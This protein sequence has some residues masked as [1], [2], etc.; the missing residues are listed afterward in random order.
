V[1]IS[2][3]IL[4]ASTLLLAVSCHNPDIFP[5]NKNK[6][7]E[8]IIKKGH[9]YCGHTTHFTKE[10]FLQFDAIFDQSAEYYLDDDYYQS[11]INKLFGFT[12]CGSTVHENSVRFGWRWYNGRLEIFAYC[13]NEGDRNYQYITSVNLDQEYNY[14]IFLDEHKYIFSVNNEIVEMPRGC[15]ETHNKNYLYP[16]FGG[17]VK[18][19]HDITIK[20]RVR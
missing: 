4:I 7:K 19:P 20:I 9:H 1:K 10:D 16:Y 15:A 17:E 8:Y 13:Y 12:D 6:F 2:S 14:K 18:A 11:D 5:H 3:Y